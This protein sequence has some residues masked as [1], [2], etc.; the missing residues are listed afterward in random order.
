MKSKRPYN[1]KRKR[2][3]R[4]PGSGNGKTCGRGH[5]GQHSRSGSG[6]SAGFEGGQMT[7]VRRL[8]KRGFS[9]IRFKKEVEIVNVRTLAQIGESEIT[10]AVLASKGI[11]DKKV[12]S[13]KVLGTGKIDKALTVHA[14]FFSESA[15]K[16]IEAAGGKAVVLTAAK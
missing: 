3:G 16:K 11:I 8:P 10:P 12:K 15:Q 7:Y 13:L 5:K 4:G 14:N 9:N 1:K 6:K 2:V